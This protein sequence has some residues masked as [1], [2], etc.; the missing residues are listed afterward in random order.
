MPNLHTL[1]S[2]NIRLWQNLPRF[3]Q[4]ATAGCP[5]YRSRKRF[6][7]PFPYRSPGRFLSPASPKCHSS[8]WHIRENAVH[9]PFQYGTPDIFH[10]FPSW[11]PPAS[12]RNCSPLFTKYIQWNSVLWVIF[13]YQIFADVF[14]WF[15][16][17]R[18]FTVLENIGTIWYH[19]SGYILYLCTM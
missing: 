12:S 18:N 5:K 15:E 10:G 4:Q 14:I 9:V 1:R 7:H 3:C 17:S 19:I 6:H 11:F 16:Y 13:V 8:V 2:R